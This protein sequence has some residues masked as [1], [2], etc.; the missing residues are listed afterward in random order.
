MQTCT[1]TTMCREK[2]GGERLSLNESGTAAEF[3]VMTDA[4]GR[5]PLLR[6]EDEIR[7]NRVDSPYEAGFFLGGIMIKVTFPDG[8]ARE[9]EKGVQLYEIARS[10]SE[11]LA[12]NV[13]GAVV[14]GETRGLQETLTENASVRFVR[15]EDPEGKAIFGIPALILWRLPSSVCTPMCVLPSDLP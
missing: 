1:L 7:W 8:S 10:I 9:Y 5:Y 15:F 3:Q 4:W 13:L 11:G 14:N 12:R 6:S 2:P